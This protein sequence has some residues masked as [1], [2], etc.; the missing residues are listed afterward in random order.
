MEEWKDI[1]G[2]EEFYQVSNLGNVRSIDRRVP[3]RRGLL[4]GAHLTPCFNGNY[5]HLKLSKCNVCT[6][7]MI[8]RLVAIHFV[9]NPENKPCVNHLDGNKLNNAANNLEWTT[10][11]ENTRHAI[12]VLGIALGGEKHYAAKLTDQKVLEIIRLAAEGYNQNELSKMFGVSNKNIGY[13]I[14]RKTWKHLKVA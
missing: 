2:Y 9:A 8:H 13:I 1:V 4:R 6:M 3:G 14:R 7:W 11:A 5:Y 12:D 10:I